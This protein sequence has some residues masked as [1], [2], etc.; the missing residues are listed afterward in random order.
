[1][2]DLEDMLRGFERL[3]HLASDPK[4]IIPGHDPLVCQLFPQDG[5][6]H[7]FRLDQGPD[8]WTF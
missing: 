1:M 8:H 2:V 7:I 5:P 4:L 3:H 6:N